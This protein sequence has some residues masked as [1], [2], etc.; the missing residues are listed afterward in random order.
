[1]SLNCLIISVYFCGMMSTFPFLRFNPPITSASLKRQRPV[2]PTG[3]V[4][5]KSLESPE[6]TYTHKEFVGL[7]RGTPSGF[8]IWHN[9]KTPT[10]NPATDIQEVF[11]AVSTSKDDNF[12]ELLGK[13]YPSFD[14]V[15]EMS[16]PPPNFCGLDVLEPGFVFNG[17]EGRQRIVDHCLSQPTK[18][19]VLIENGLG[20]WAALE[21][22]VSLFQTLLEQRGRCSGIVKGN[23]DLYLDY[24]G[25]MSDVATSDVTP[26]SRY[27][28]LGFKARRLDSDL[29]A[30]AI[31]RADKT[32]KRDKK[33]RK[34]DDA[35]TERE[36]AQVYN[37]VCKE[38]AVELSKMNEDE[39]NLEKYKQ[40]ASDACTDTT[41]RSKRSSL[42][43]EYAKNYLS[44]HR[45]YS[46]SGLC[47]GTMWLF[48]DFEREQSAG[49][50]AVLELSLS[51][52]LINLLQGA[53]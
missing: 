10:K 12:N 43:V 52:N 2:R 50:G 8:K 25:L 46:E 6:R 29:F 48:D 11:Y 37:L 27:Y 36:E 47:V 18:G 22:F 44:A 7:M 28:F 20:N 34:F 40:Q 41:S 17:E 38:L 51:T 33:S 1:M 45:V 5:Y 3:P 42:Y 49:I 4:V 21:I 31:I 26:N 30:K 53:P 19:E 16:V 39:T 15:R 24:I 14:S 13:I 23:Q 32:P 35:L 9:H